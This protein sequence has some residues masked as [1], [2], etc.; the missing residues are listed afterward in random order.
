M[1]CGNI[2][3]CLGTLAP[4]MLLMIWGSTGKL[5]AKVGHLEQKS[6]LILWDPVLASLWCSGAGGR[7]MWCTDTSFYLNGALFFIVTVPSL[8]CYLTSLITC[9]FTQ[10]FLL[11]SLIQDLTS[12]NHFPEMASFKAGTYRPS[13]LNGKMLSFSQEL[14][15][16]HTKCRCNPWTILV[17]RVKPSGTL[18][19]QWPIALESL[20][21]E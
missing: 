7:R 8:I 17:A 18:S 3:W 4:E 20:V 14:D 21:P 1:P 19:I 9:S 6:F 16:S 5:I 11:Y 15:I 10:K 12:R 13:P 2:T